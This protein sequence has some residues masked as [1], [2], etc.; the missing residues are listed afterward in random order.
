VA[1]ALRGL[2]LLPVMGFEMAGRSGGDE[3]DVGSAE[4]GLTVLLEACER[5]VEEIGPAVPPA[6]L[7]ALLIIERDGS[8]NLNRLAT[9]LGAS[10]SAASRLLDRMQAAGLVSRDRAAASRREILVIPTESGQRLA[11]WVRSRRRAALTVLLEGMTADGRESLTR[12][13]T[14]LADGGVSGYD[15]ASSG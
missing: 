15:A 11:E 8:L 1:A 9:S 4:S 10:A 13:L 3:L 2:P 14:E 5:A 12:G 7:R 6:Q